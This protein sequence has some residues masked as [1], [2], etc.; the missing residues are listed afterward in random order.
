[1][2]E[3]CL[4]ALVAQAPE[5]NVVVVD[6][7]SS[8]ATVE[9]A[10]R[11]RAHVIANSQNRG[12]AGAVNQVCADIP[13]DHLVLLLNPDTE[14][15]TPLGPL[16]EKCATA[17]LGAGKL[18]D[19][20][21]NTQAGF[22]VR[23]FPTPWSLV[24]ELLGINR[25]WPQN[26][27]N[28]RYRYADRDL[29]K[30]GP[31]EQPAGAFLM[32]RRNVWEKL[33][34]FDERFFPVWFEDVDFCQRAVLAGF[35]IEYV[36]FVYARHAGGHSVSVLPTEA[37]ATYWCV[38]LLRYAAKYYG[39]LSFRGLCLAVMLSS[40]PRM[41]LAAFQNPRGDRDRNLRPSSAFLKIMAFAGQCLWSPARA[42]R[43]I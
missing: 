23:R 22:T 41:L 13:A 18:V 19:E 24:F 39:P 25:L 27:I 26:Y 3:R 43:A 37:R 35:S 28:R 31:V 11:H 20:N 36:P 4:G 9:R 16:T 7:A 6:N 15:L 21:G 12:F 42:W 30:P 33:G 29:E 14:L 1:M 17:G 34:G 40:V 5:V 32:F 10:R 38:S 2:I 8:D